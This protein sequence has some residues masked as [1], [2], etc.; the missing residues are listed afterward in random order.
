MGARTIAVVNVG[1]IGCMPF[2]RTVGVSLFGGEKNCSE[3][4]NQAALLY[5]ARLRSLITEL[6]NNLKGSFFLHADVYRIF[7]DIVLN[8]RSYGTFF[9]FFH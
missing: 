1:P 3:T 2:E 8:Y 4:A 5:D 7:N 6:S 9:L